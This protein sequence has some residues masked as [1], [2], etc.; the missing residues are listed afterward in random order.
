MFAV[1]FFLFPFIVY[2][3][4][5]SISGA[6]SIL[7]L[8]SNPASND[9]VDSSDASPQN[10]IA[11]AFVSQADSVWNFDLTLDSQDIID[12]NDSP[13]ENIITEAFVSHAD[14]VFSTKLE[15]DNW[16]PLS[17]TPVLIVPGILGSWWESVLPSLSS[18]KLVIDPIFHAYDDLYGALA[19]N[20]YIP[21]QTLFTFPYDWRIDNRFNA[22][23]LRD[24]IS[25]IKTIC[26]CQKVN[27]IA[28][29]MGGLVARYYIES[30][31][32]KNDID[33]LVLLGTPNKGA[34]EAYLSWEAG[35]SNLFYYTFFYKIL[36]KTEG[37]KNAFDY[38]RD[39]PLTSVEQ[40]LPVYNYLKSVT[41]NSLLAYP[42]D[43]PKNDFLGES[44][45]D[46]GLNSP[47]KLAKL[48]N[49]GV[50]ITNITANNSK[51]D[52]INIIRIVKDTSRLPLWEHGYPQNFDNLLG[53]RGL[54]RGA[55]DGDVPLSS[56]Q[57][58]NLSNVRK[59]NLNSDHLG[60]PTDAFYTI[61]NLF[62]GK[63]AAPIYP[64]SLVRK[65]LIVPVFS[66]VD[67]QITDPLGRK[68]GKNFLTGQSINEIPLAYYTGFDNP[69]LEF[70]AI[71]NPIDGEYTINTQGTDTGTYE[72][73]SIFMN[74][75]VVSGS[76]TFTANTQPGLTEDLSF[77][78]SS[79]APDQLSIVP[80]D[81]TPPHTDISLSGTSGENKWFISDVVVSLSAKDNDNGTGVLKTEYSLDNGG[82]WNDYISPFT[83]SEE[84][85]NK[86]LYRS[87]DFVG[88]KEEIK[89][90]EIKIDKTPPEAK[91]YFDKENHTLKIEGT[92]NLTSN[93]KV[94]S[95]IEET[96]LDNSEAKD[97]DNDIKSESAEIGMEIESFNQIN[98]EKKKIIYQIKDDAGHVLN[99]TFRRI[100]DKNHFIYAFLNSLQYDNNPII[101]LPKTTLNYLWL[102]NR[103]NEFRYL[104]QRII[105]KNKF[106]VKSL[107]NLLQNK[108]F[109]FIKNE[110]EKEIKQTFSGIKIIKLTT[111][112]GSLN[113]E[114]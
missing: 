108:S 21:N 111:K 14:A 25:E 82:T 43:Y 105:T 66:P 63:S 101:S 55:G 10:L 30:N 89:S 97:I 27:I 75:E 13:P 92:D 44:D 86:I 3:E 104:F 102:T 31:L 74:D 53:D 100:I 90:Q 39:K 72:V 4:E 112:S 79:T 62:T 37:F 38:I 40:L 52:T 94:I 87:E 65:I 46:S 99:L 83:I 1:C 113:Y 81:I 109:V 50:K 22:V 67:I 7:N 85:A 36:A 28:H 34:P 64:S 76:S 93:P 35:E 80:E 69:D 114:Y 45:S 6:D 98:T 20:G 73:Q 103:K 26:N 60:L 17:K 49:S 96:K 61:F 77:N 84:G 54:E 9:V 58:L 18:G 33:Q 5:L 106:S 41:D 12:S 95:K 88:N 24:K 59:I 107:Y 57:S 56:A 110:G 71:P 42:N 32:Y 47:S 68:V 48:E 2:S 78:F 91:I 19:N 51:N 16:K 15:G 8:E 70:V 29:S 23:F 11:F